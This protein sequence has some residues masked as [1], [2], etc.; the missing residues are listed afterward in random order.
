MLHYWEYE[1]KSTIRDVNV[2]WILIYVSLI[3]AI[4]W[5]LVLSLYVAYENK[6]FQQTYCDDLFML[7]IQMKYP[8]RNVINWIDTKV[9]SYIKRILWFF[10]SLLYFYTNIR[11]QEY[12]LLT[13]SILQMYIIRFVRNIPNFLIAYFNFWS[14]NNKCSI[15]G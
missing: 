5:M 12:R 4:V 7:I 10:S 2:I 3:I 14:I 8:S 11:A 15:K 1:F 9:C 13:I 6:K